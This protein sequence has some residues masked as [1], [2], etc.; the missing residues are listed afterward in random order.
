MKFDIIKTILS[1]LSLVIYYLL[2]LLEAC[3]II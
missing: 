1:I 2:L 3:H